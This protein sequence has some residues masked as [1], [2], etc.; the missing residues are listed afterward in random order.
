ML[1]LISR[2]VS[3]QRAMRARVEALREECLVAA[4][5]LDELRAEKAPTPPNVAARLT[6]HRELAR[7]VAKQRLLRELHKDLDQTFATD[8]ED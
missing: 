6:T 4:R 1:K 2:K 8:S 5:L 7:V 3:P